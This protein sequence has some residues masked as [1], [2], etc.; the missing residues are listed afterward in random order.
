M[1]ELDGV[2]IKEFIK[3][4]KQAVKEACSTEQIIILGFYL[5]GYSADWIAKNRKRLQLTPK[6][7]NVEI[8]TAIS[9]I[10]TQI[11]SLYSPQLLA[12]LAKHIDSI[13]K[14]L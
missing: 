2:D 5:D 14:Y 7:V 12:E 10:A 4:L 13:L 8:E 9:N 3:H 11:R 6:Q 1:S